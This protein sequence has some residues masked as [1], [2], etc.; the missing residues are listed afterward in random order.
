MTKLYNGDCRAIIKDIKPENCIVITDPPFNVGY[1]YNSYSD[2]LT[3]DR[4]NVN[5]NYEPSNCRWADKKTQA[6]NTRA[7]HFYTYKGETKTIAEWAEIKNMNYKKLWK[8]IKHN[9]EEDNIF[10]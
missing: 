5:G 9:W 6:R 2:N 1:H 4:I 8:R 7:N 3:I 10:N